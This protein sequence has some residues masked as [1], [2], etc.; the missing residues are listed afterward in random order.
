MDNNGFSVDE[1]SG[2]E[3]WNPKSFSARAGMKA[4]LLCRLRPIV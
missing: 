4:T 3:S 1:G 2:V